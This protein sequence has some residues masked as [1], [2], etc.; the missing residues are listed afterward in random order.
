MFLNGVVEMFT[1]WG[2]LKEALVR[3]AGRFGREAVIVGHDFFLFYNIPLRHAA[4]PLGNPA[5]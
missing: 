2:V 4:I 3:R 5:V 1:K